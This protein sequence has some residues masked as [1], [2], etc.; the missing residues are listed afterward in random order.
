MEDNLIFIIMGLP[1]KKIP[2]WRYSNVNQSDG[3]GNVLCD[4]IACN[5]LTIKVSLNI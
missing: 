3:L 5:N 2:T 4:Q 1:L